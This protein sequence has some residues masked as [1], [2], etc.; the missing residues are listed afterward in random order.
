MTGNCVATTE[1]AVEQTGQRC[2]A[3]GVAVKSAQ[4]WNCA[5]RKI[6]PR[7]SAKI[8]I[9]RALACMYLLRRSLGWNGCRVKLSAALEAR[10]RGE[11]PDLSL[12]LREIGFCFVELRPVGSWTADFGELGVKRLR[13][14]CVAG[15]L[16]RA[17][18]A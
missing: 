17:G 15:G 5:P 10:S 1:A 11:T 8:R 16:R 7:S 9:C 18:G 2:E 6:T 13:V 4:R 12:F 14:A 3:D